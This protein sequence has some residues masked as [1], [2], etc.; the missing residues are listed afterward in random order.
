MILWLVN[1]QIMT[2]PHHI[3]CLEFVALLVEANQCF[4]EDAHFDEDF[5]KA[6]LSKLYQF[7]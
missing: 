3:S 2:E 1:L 6:A 5:I 4:K 7:P